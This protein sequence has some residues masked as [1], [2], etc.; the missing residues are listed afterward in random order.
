VTLQPKHDRSEPAAALVAYAARPVLASDLPS[1][2]VSPDFRS[3]VTETNADYV[4]G[5]WTFL[6]TWTVESGKKFAQG[7]GARAGTR[8][9]SMLYQQDAEFGDMQVDVVLTHEKGDASGFGSPGSSIDGALIQKSDLFIKYDPR[10]RNG[11]SLRY[12][13]TKDAE[14]KCVFQLFRHTNGAGSPLSDRQVVSGVLLPSTHVTLKVVGTKFT[15][16]LRNDVN[17]ETVSL[18]ETIEP[19]KFG[20][21]GVFW[22]GT[23]Y[24]GNSIA[25]SQFKITSPGQPGQ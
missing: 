17:Q 15:A 20:G 7:W 5:R 2:D 21:A 22:S 25:Y 19:N 3:F 8:G 13:R 4:S 18:A 23:V 14:N 6:G 16:E 1:L 11:Y 24:R 9:A 12:W 10:T